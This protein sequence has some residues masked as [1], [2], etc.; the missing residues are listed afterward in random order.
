MR[1]TCFPPLQDSDPVGFEPVLGRMFGDTGPWP[2]GGIYNVLHFG[3]A[4][5]GGINVVYA[6]GAVRS[7][8]YEID[9]VLFNALGTR[10]GEESVPA[11]AI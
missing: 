1:S 4:H 10:N 11:D 2:V 8:Q 6:D 3:S 5:V 7:I 9:P